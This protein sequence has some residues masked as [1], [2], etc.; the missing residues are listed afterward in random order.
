M[1]LATPQKSSGIKGELVQIA[2]STCT[3]DVD[4]TALTVGTIGI[5]IK[6]VSVGNVPISIAAVGV[7]SIPIDI[8]SQ[9]V[10]NIAVNIA[11]QAA[12][13]LG[14]DI[15]AQT[16]G[17]IGIDIKAQTVGNIAV[18]IAAS[19]I[20]LQVNI[21]SQSA[22]LNVAIAASSVTLQINIASQTSNLN[23]NI[24]ASAVTLNIQG[25]AGGTAVAISGTVSI[26][27]TVTVSGTV[28]ISG[29]VTVTGTVAISGTVTV[30]GTVAISGT[31]TVTGAVTVSGSV[32]IS[33]TVTISGNVTVVGPLDVNGNV[34]IAGT[35]TVSGTVTVTG[36]VSITG[37]VT[38]TGSVSITGTV[39]VTGA[40]T[41][42]GSVS[43]TGTVTV[44]GTVAVSG[45]VTVSGTVAISGTVTVSGSVSVSGT[46]SISGTVTISGAVTIS[47]TVTITGA[48]TITSG[49][50]TISTSGG[51]NIIIDKLTQAA[52]TCRDAY[53]S[54]DNGVTTPTAPPSSRTGTAY[55]GKWFPRGM[56]GAYM[57]VTIYCKRTGAG[58]ITL[59]FSP[60]PGM[61][62]IFTVTI[63]PS[64][65][66]NW[67]VGW[68]TRMWNYDS[69]FIWIKSCGA[70]VSW[71]YDTAEPYD[72]F[73][74][75]DS[76]VRWYAE[77]QRLFIK[78]YSI[79]QSVGDLPVSGT[80]NTIEIPSQS[81]ERLYEVYNDLPDAE[82][83]IKTI[84]GAGNTEYLLLHVDAVSKGENTS[85]KIYC[86]GVVAW[87]WS[88]KSM[89]DKGYSTSTPGM[90][91]IKYAA[92]GLCDIHLTLKF[93]FK[94]ELKITG[95]ADGHVIGGGVP[96]VM[97]EGM[98]NL[99]R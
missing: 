98:V 10:G 77:Y 33:G 56:R 2:A 43:I 90:T 16:V 27:G 28:S 85:F 66:W 37:T 82:T 62:E 72:E 22:N 96:D 23:M 26:T 57:D 5:D 21:A 81:Q 12:F 67:Q 87:W 78:S 1:G 55:Y 95:R 17:N 83:T 40:V 52:Y 38:I 36:S 97:V 35:V 88:F 48:V 44:S 73:S 79:R 99:I 61:G 41:V 65:T 76:G 50:V 11:A 53:M 51:A 75:P 34:K 69:L 71:G 20:T 80:I 30:S 9:T 25:V 42:S 47:G 74:S 18:N 45:T 89:N 58:T 19:A 6:A 91:L 84:D 86:D 49:A 7:A 15:K 63:T 94:R 32:S 13:N 31:V 92:D 46:V 39:T 64:D 24:A 4:I 68:P 3:L 14:V 70:D 54:N 59:A 93:A 29:S 8:K 60:Q